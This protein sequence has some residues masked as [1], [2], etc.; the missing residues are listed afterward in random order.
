MCVII[1][2]D[3]FMR[4]AFKFKMIILSLNIKLSNDVNIISHEFFGKERLI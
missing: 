3:V 1:M 2:R 4:D